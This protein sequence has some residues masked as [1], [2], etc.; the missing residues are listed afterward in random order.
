MLLCK[1]LMI[2][3][4]NLPH[5]H[6]HLQ[7]LNLPTANITL[8]V[9]NIHQRLTPPVDLVHLLVIE[10]LTGMRNDPSLSVPRSPRRR[11]RSRD[12]SPRRRQGSPSYREFSHSLVCV[13]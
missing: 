12:P 13:S 9:A 8:P 4:Y 7:H 2:E 10:N 5:L 3:P 11:R 1:R 6:H